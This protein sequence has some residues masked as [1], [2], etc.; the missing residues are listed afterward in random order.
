MITNIPNF[1]SHDEA[2]EL[3]C[4]IDATP[5]DWWTHVYKHRGM[6][7]YGAWSPSVN[8]YRF[9]NDIEQAIKNSVQNGHFSYRFRRSTEHVDNC[10]CYS[11]TFKNEVLLSER[12]YSE[13]KAA[14]HLEDPVLGETFVSFYGPGD[15]LGVHTDEGKGIAFIVNLSWDWKPEY[16]GI[17]NVKNEGEDSYTSIVPGWGNLVLLD[18]ASEGHEH[19]VSE[20]SD[21]AARPR[22]A[23]T[24]WYEEGSSKPRVSKKKAPVKETTPSKKKPLYCRP[25]DTSCTQELLSADIVKLSGLIPDQW[26]KALIESCENNGQWQ[27]L[28]DDKFPGQE[29]RLDTLTGTSFFSDLKELYED[30][31]APE[32]EAHWPKLGLQGLQDAFVIKYATNQQ[33]SLPLHTDS[34]SVSFTIKLNDYYKGGVLNFPRQEVTNESCQVGDV[35]YWP[36]EVTHPHESLPLEKGVKYSLVIWTKK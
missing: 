1:L 17:L 29:I 20:V 14:T 33:E 3:A 28:P 27:S 8:G 6:E 2:W 19:F 15:Y 26:C 5:L 35:L 9:K 30:T 12:M 32:A 25:E 31:L 22:I 21:L 36:S 24:G 4:A 16:G 11:C 23:I 18:I 13:V 7:S 34:S 10:N